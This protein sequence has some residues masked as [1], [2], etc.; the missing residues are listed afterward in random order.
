[1]RSSNQILQLRPARLAEYI[2][3][4]DRRRQ[5]SGVIPRSIR[6]MPTEAETWTVAVPSV[7][8]SAI[9]RMMLATDELTRLLSAVGTSTAN[10]SPPK[11]AQHEPSGEHLRI[12]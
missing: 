1:M 11:R 3:M 9:E 8:V 2:A 5:S 12:T 4:S 7:R 6:E 10:S